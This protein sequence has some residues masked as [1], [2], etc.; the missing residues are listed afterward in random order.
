M[1]RYALGRLGGAARDAGE[2][3]DRSGWKTE[4]PERRRRVKTGSAGPSMAE[5]LEPLYGSFADPSAIGEFLA[6]LFAAL[7]SESGAIMGQDSALG[8]G[9]VLAQHGLPPDWG[10]RYAERV[11]D[12]NPIAPYSAPFHF[13]GSAFRTSDCLPMRQFRRWAYY[14][15]FFHPNGI[16]YSVNHVIEGSPSRVLLISAAR[17]GRRGDYDDRD[18][19]FLRAI[20]P[21]LQRVARLHRLTG[22]IGLSALR[23]W[24]GLRGTGSAA[25]LVNAQGRTAQTSDA[26]ESLLARGHPIRLAAGGRIVFTDP[27]LAA[28]FAEVVAEASRALLRSS[29]VAGDVI[30][31]ARARDRQ[32]DW[33]R[34]GACKLPASPLEVVPSDLLLVVE[35]GSSAQTPSVPDERMREHGLTQAEA[36]LCRALLDDRTGVEAATMLGVSITTVRTQLRSIFRKTGTKRQTELVKL[37]LS[38]RVLGE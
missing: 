9:G 25:C 19:A 5:L 26:M 4:A 15:E 24:V 35:G 3:V 29:A 37:L 23:A 21:H 12:Q 7:R 28:A 13:P 38:S 17:Q 27:A 22:A 11:A 18:L 30:S 16:L 6:R 8:V 20:D 36:R 14:D 10:T 31:W 2:P 1:L 34:L 33:W 32:G